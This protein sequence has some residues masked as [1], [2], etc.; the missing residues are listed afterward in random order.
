MTLDTEW[1][2]RI[3][4]ELEPQVYLELERLEQESTYMETQD[5][6][7]AV[8]N[9]ELVNCTRDE[10]IATIRTALQEYA[11]DRVDNGDALRMYL[12]LSEVKRLDA[13]YKP[14]GKARAS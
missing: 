5:A 8:H 7:N 4:K 14:F 9:G 2:S 1:W 13:L 11:S 3:W 10:Y 6:L 12:A